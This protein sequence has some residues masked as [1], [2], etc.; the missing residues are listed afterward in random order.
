MN[1]SS[2]GYEKPLYILPFDHR[3]TFATELF[4]KKSINDLTEE[5]RELIREFKMLIYKGFK[6][7][8]EQKVPTDNAAILCDEEFGEEVLLDARHN[9]YITILTIEK[10]GQ[11]TFEFQYENFKEHIEKFKPTFTKVLIKYNPKDSEEIKEKQQKNLKIISDYSHENT[12]KFLLEVLVL[13]TKEQL[14]QVGGSRDDYDVKLRPELTAEVVRSF[15][16]R[17]IEPDVW[18][19]EGMDSANDYAGVIDE[20]KS[21][22]REKVSIVILGRGAKEEKLEQWLKMGSKV[23]GVTGFAVGRTIFWN[24]IEKF[25]KGEIGKAEVIETISQKFQD[26]Y[27]VFTSSK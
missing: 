7:A 13:P 27:T 4:G 5:E 6:K 21:G 25:Y 19:L 14:K 10:S 1:L 22:G 8:V 20:V 9:G 16:A 24:P 11:E 2:L 15:Q 18:K 26:F 23:N 17:G 12:Y 3:A